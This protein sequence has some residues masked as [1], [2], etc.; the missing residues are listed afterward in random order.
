[1]EYAKEMYD[2]KQL[3]RKIVTLQN[4]AELAGVSKSVAS[5]LL[6]NVKTVISVSEATR[7]KVF[8]AAA[9]LDY[10]PCGGARR[11]VKHCDAIGLVYQASDFFQNEFIRCCLD[12]IIGAA[13]SHNYTISLGVGKSKDERFGVKMVDDR[14]VDGILVMPTDLSG[15][16]TSYLKK[17]RMPYVLVN[18]GEPLSTDA[19]CCD[20]VGGAEK[21]ME[22]LRGLGHTRIC[23]LTSTS[24]HTSVRIRRS[25]YT[26]RMEADGVEP[27]VGP[28]S[29]ESLRE[30]VAHSVARRKATAFFLYEDASAI[31]FYMACHSLGIAIPGDV[32]VIGV[33][34]GASCVR[35]LP[36]LTSIRLPVWEMGVSAVEM[37]VR[38]LK[39]NV[40][41]PSITFEE[42]LIVRDSCRAVE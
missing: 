5:R 41:Q 40:S 17:E 39:H 33:N 23:H 8:E 10:K 37:L 7:V 42:T 3:M 38:R 12:G 11:L 35:I 28:A 13:D 4:V 9:E 30:F 29:G 15:P 16:L 32:S 25:V 36:Q 26:R 6:N 34:D 24:S 31:D 1:M 22:Y 20:D 18:P 14:S 19:I 21:A 27:V 2:G